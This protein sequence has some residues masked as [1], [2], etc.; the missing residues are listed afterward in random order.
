MPPEP[1]NLWLKD[2]M[3]ELLSRRSKKG[4]DPVETWRYLYSKLFKIADANDIPSP[5]E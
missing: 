1:D 3:D 4:E 5:C 2:G